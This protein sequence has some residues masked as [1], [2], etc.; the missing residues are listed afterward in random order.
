MEWK[1]SFVPNIRAVSAL[2]PAAGAAPPSPDAP[3]PARC[4][5]PSSAAPPSRR[6]AA[7]PG[8]PA[9]WPRARALPAPPRPAALPGQAPPYP[10]AASASRSARLRL[11]DAFHAFPQIRTC[12]G[13]LQLRA[14]RDGGGGASAA[15]EGSALLGG[16]GG[17]GGGGREGR[18][19][20]ARGNGA[21]RLDDAGRASDLFSARNCAWCGD[22]TIPKQQ[23]HDSFC[24]H[25]LAKFPKTVIAS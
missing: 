25:C 20:P 11:R 5:R 14:L 12:S 15:G 19:A 1:Q 4:P 7:L 18:A 2:P 10:P 9:P 24:L 6:R 23:K 3:L 22:P 21:M 13:E 8:R 16:R 17:G